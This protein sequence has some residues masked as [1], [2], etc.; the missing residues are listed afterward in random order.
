M[1]NF[2]VSGGSMVQPV[3][4]CMKKYAHTQVNCEHFGIVKIPQCSRIPD[5]YTAEAR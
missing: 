2:N 5:S 4:V 1:L 3:K